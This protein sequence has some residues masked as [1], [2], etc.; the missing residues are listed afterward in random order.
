MLPLE[1][2]ILWISHRLTTNMEMAARNNMKN[3]YGNIDILLKMELQITRYVIFQLI[4]KYCMVKSGTSP[5]TAR[6]LLP[7][8]N[9]PPLNNISQKIRVLYALL[10][11]KGS[12]LMQLQIDGFRRF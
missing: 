5:M 7:M 12:I 11:Q 10:S 1:E 6:L 8:L 4:K 9:L 2:I 3:T